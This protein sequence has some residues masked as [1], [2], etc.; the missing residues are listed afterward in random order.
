MS[1]LV[2]TYRAAVPSDIDDL[3]RVED[4]VGVEGPLYTPYQLHLGFIQEH[5]QVVLPLKPHT[6]FT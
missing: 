3:A 4:E 2:L 1:A 6:V 5:P